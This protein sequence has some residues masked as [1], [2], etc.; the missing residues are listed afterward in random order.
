MKPSS[1]DMIIDVLLMTNRKWYDYTY[2][3]REYT[4]TLQKSMYHLRCEQKENEH[5]ASISNEILKG[6]QYLARS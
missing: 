4:G 6:Y 2:G 5:K 3:E 1:V